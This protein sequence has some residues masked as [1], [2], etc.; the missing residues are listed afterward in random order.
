MS[1]K[2]YLQVLRS[3]EPHRPGRVRRDGPEDLHLPTVRGIGA[4]GIAQRCEVKLRGAHVLDE[5]AGVQ[6]PLLAPPSDVV[7]LCLYYKLTTFGGKFFSL[8]RSI[9]WDYS[10]PISTLFIL[11]FA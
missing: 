11:I 2:L 6:R 8:G 4:A 3:G 9:Q 5:E 10:N 7:I 1:N